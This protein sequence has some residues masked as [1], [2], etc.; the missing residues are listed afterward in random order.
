M[1]KL[2]LIFTFTLV[3]FYKNQYPHYIVLHQS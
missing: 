2:Y 1:E 3:E